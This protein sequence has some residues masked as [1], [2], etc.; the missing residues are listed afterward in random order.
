MSDNPQQAHARFQERMLDRVSRTFALT[1]PLLPEDLPRVV[2]NGYLLCRIADTIEDDAALTAADKS[3]Y[4]KRFVAVVEGDEDPVAFS[5]ELARALAPETSAAER[6]LVARTAEVLAIT[7]TFNN[8][9]FAAIQ[10]CVRTM[11]IGMAEFQGSNPVSGLSDLASF[12]SYCYHVAGVVGELLTTLF[13][14]YSAPVAKREPALRAFA[15]SF[16]QGL[17]MTNILKDI[18]EDRRRGACWLPRDLFLRHG[19]DLSRSADFSPGAQFS[20]ALRELAAIAKQHLHRAI[21]YSVTIPRQ[22]RGIRKFCILPVAMALLTLRK[23]SQHPQ[24]HSGDEIKI[25]RRSV[26]FS[27]LL[28]AVSVRSDWLMRTAFESL[29]RTVS[30]PAQVQAAKWAK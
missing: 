27:G 5:G 26:K 12:N 3:H 15:A 1:I 8:I 16:G 9:Q 17:Q 21:L 19:I 22:E 14:D 25:S 23:I 13:C 6:E 10:R 30:V 24:F 2:G 7:R 11:A 20:N 29:A 28:T 18:W 4:A